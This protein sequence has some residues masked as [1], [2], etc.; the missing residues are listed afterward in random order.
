MSGDERWLPVI[1]WEGLY[2]IS[3][4]GAVRS[5]PRIVSAGPRAHQRRASGRLLKPAL[6]KRGYFQATLCRDGKDRK[7]PVH[8]LIL[9]AFIGPRPPGMECCHANDI[10]TDN[11]L[12]NLRWDTTSANSYDRVRNGIHPMSRKTHCKNGHP[13]DKTNTGINYR[14]ARWCRQCNRDIKRRI[15]T[16]CQKCARGMHCDFEHGVG[17]HNYHGCRCDIC[18]KA[19]SARDHDAYMRRCNRPPK[20]LELFTLGGGSC[21]A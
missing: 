11:R 1:G 7:R 8:Q 18:R 3:D 17:G 20:Q 9:E 13:F 16:G 21:A 5:L 15:G 2:E 12:E 19:K 10:K 14:G 4:R 6:T